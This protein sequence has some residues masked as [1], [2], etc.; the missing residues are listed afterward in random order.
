MIR[1]LIIGF[2]TEGTTDVRFLESVIQRSFEGIAFE[3]DGQIEVLPVQY[4]KKQSGSFVTVVQTCA[5]QAQEQ[6]VMVLCIHTDADDIAD[7]NAFDYKISPAF[8]SINNMREDNLCNNLVAIV[9]V[10]MTEAWMLSDKRLLKSEIGTSK[11]DIELGIH[12]PP[13]DYSDPKQA[14]EEAIRIA[15]QD[16]PRH[17]RRELSIGELYSIIGQKIELD[18]L[19]NLPSYQKFKAAVRN[20]FRRLNY[21]H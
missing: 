11:S 12:R 15:R 6:G 8:T 14:I 17:R 19:A 10:Q 16:L 21:L 7:T 2:T 5:Q 1:Q 20:A 3:C 9:P 18:M 4:I 13:E